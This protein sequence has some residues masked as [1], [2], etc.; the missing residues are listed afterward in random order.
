MLLLTTSYLQCGASAVRLVPGEW[1]RR[2][3]F[4]VRRGGGGVGWAVR[5][6]GCRQRGRKSNEAESLSR[7]PGQ[8]TKP[9]GAESFDRQ[10]MSACGNSMHPVSPP[11]PLAS[12]HRKGVP[13]CRGPVGGGGSPVALTEMTPPSHEHLIAAERPL[14]VGVFSMS[15][16]AP[17]TVTVVTPPPGTGVRRREMP[18]ELIDACLASRAPRWR[19][20]NGPKHALKRG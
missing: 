7:R 19:R 11:V 10:S 1:T 12:T 2:R 15:G 6:M 20:A 14:S 8:S 3:A 17:A 18:S 4:G 5:Q 16:T 9:D 13:V